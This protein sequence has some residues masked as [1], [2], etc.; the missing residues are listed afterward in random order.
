LYRVLFLS[1]LILFA[2]TFAINTMAELIR[3]RLR[4]KYSQF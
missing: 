3:Q 4:Q 2:F 1:G